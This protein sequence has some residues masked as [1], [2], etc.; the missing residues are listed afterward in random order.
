[1][2]VELHG[3]QEVNQHPSHH[4]LLLLQ[5]LPQ[6]DLGPAEIP[7]QL[8]SSQVTNSAEQEPPETSVGDCVLVGHQIPNPVGR[9][10]IR[11][12]HVQLIFYFLLFA[13]PGQGVARY[14]L[15]D[16][17]VISVTRE[18]KIKYPESQSADFPNVAGVEFSLAEGVNFLKNSP[19]NIRDSTLEL[20]ITF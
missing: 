4:L 18:Y 3:E 5:H 16:H 7:R 15:G 12:G 10:H 17:R 11:G 2:R 9:C 1:M 13:M 8:E 14:C 6:P 19:V 20:V